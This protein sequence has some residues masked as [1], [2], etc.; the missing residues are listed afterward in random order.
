[1]LNLTHAH[2]TNT[3]HH[4]S[5]A[6]EERKQR[7][8]AAAVAEL[9]TQMHQHE[10]RMLQLQAEN[11]ALRGI[12]AATCEHAAQTK[13][14]QQQQQQQQQQEATVAKKACSDKATATL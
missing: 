1:M 5:A 10:Q 2:N 13:D 6:R 9:H 7:E 3:L 11:A 4:Y 8:V 14:Q 12:V